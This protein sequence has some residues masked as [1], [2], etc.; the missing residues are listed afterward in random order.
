MIGGRAAPS[1]RRLLAPFFKEKID[2][3]GLY[4][5]CTMLRFEQVH[6]VFLNPRYIHICKVSYNSYASSYIIRKASAL[7]TV[8]YSTSY[9]LNLDETRDP[10]AGFFAYA[11]TERTQGLRVYKMELP[12]PDPTED[13]FTR[14]YRTS[15]AVDATTLYEH[16]IEWVSH[17]PNC[18][19]DEFRVRV[20]IPSIS[21]EP[22]YAMFHHSGPYIGDMWVF[23][24]RH[25]V[26]TQHTNVGPGDPLL[27]ERQHTDVK[28]PDDGTVAYHKLYMW[29]HKYRKFNVS[30]EHY[31]LCYD[32]PELILQ[33][34][35]MP[36]WKRERIYNIFSFMG[37]DQLIDVSRREVDAV[38]TRMC[39]A[40]MCASA[41]RIVREFLKLI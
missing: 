26:S 33:N 1:S 23:R 15:R 29:I 34:T 36:Y 24:S 32:R 18:V 25:L 4:K 21:I 10:L 41:E 2:F 37:I 7:T 16:L 40:K 27:H 35:T 38:V 3:W 8:F 28:R 9:R 30:S 20:R 12:S 22:Y 6:S 31:Y 13:E 11:V 14:L 17:T 5:L 19:V 39:R